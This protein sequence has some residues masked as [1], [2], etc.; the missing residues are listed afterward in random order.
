MRMTEATSQSVIL[1]ITIIFLEPMILWGRGLGKAPLG[2]SSVPHGIKWLSGGIL[3]V[4][5][6]LCRILDSI[7]HYSIGHIGRDNQKV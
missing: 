4:D 1:K 7:T 6:L 2:D 5:E 3:L